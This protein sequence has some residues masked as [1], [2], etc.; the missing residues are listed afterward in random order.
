MTSALPKLGLVLAALLLIAPAQDG[1]PLKLTAG[2]SGL[3]EHGLDRSILTNDH[4]W[5]VLTAVPDAVSTSANF[6][7]IDLGDGPD[8]TVSGLLDESRGDLSGFDTLYL[9]VN[10]NNDLTDDGAIALERKR[11]HLT[12]VYSA[13]PV[14]L[15]ARYADGT[16]RQ[17]SYKLTLFSHSYSSFGWDDHWSMALDAQEHLE[18]TVTLGGKEVL[19]GVY[20]GMP[21]IGR[22]NGIFNEYGTDLLRI[23]TSGDGKL[24]EGDVELLLGTAFAHEGQLYTLSIDPAGREIKV[25]PWDGAPGRINVKIAYLERTKVTKMRALLSDNC[26]HIFDLDLLAEETLLVPPGRY[27]LSAGT[28]EVTDTRNGRKWTAA[29]FRREPVKVDVGGTAEL[30]IGGQGRVRTLV[31]GWHTAG[32]WLDIV[33]EVRGEGGESY[34]FIRAA[35]GQQATS[36]IEVTD[37]YGVTATGIR[38]GGCPG[39][40]FQRYVWHIPEELALTELDHGRYMIRRV[41]P[42]GPFFGILAGEKEVMIRRILPDEAGPPRTPTAKKG[43]APEVRREE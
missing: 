43:P 4:A 19:I 28:T 33:S 41:T 22:H 12:T 21:A 32:G 11:D 10:N 35:K 9:D 15:T 29:F 39:C 23:D 1:T 36:K 34:R 31:Q 5:E 13:P 16:A 18:A 6:L 40:G 42:T 26:G 2:T 14:T 20:D 17:L 30:T 27:T 7:K 25:A 3:E 38:T 24:G 8:R 37:M